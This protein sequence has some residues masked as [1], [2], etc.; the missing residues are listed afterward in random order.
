[1][2]LTPQAQAVMLLT[3]PFGKSDSARAKPLSNSEWARFA[4]WLK[5]H[6]LEPAYLLKGDLQSL[7]AGWMDRSVS[8]ARIQTLLG[9]GAALGLALEKWQRAGLW[10]LTRSDPDYPER[11]KRHLRSESPAVLFGCGDKSLLNR[12]GIAVVGSRDAS[13][14]DLAFTEKLGKCAA[15]Q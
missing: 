5:D 1:M 14:E 2:N 4:I 15:M 9:R 13:E 11:L 8:V 10:I 12:G 3:V 6:G 7:L